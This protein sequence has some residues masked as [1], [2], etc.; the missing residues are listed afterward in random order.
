[1]SAI[2]FL[3][4]LAP[5]ILTQPSN[6][7]PG[8]DTLRINAEAVKA[9]RFDFS[10]NAAEAIDRQQPQQEKTTK[11]WLDYQYDTRLLRTFIDTA[12][13]KKVNGYE[14]LNPYSIWTKLGEAPVHDVLVY[15]RPTKWEMYWQLHPELL[16]D[17]PLWK[18]WKPSVGYMYDLL[19]NSI[20]PGIGFSFSADQLLFETFTRQG[21][22]ISCNRKHAN[23]WKI[24][25]NYIP[26]KKDW[27]G[28][29]PTLLL[30]PDTLQTDSQTHMKSETD[31]LDKPILASRKKKKQTDI[32]NSLVAEMKAKQQQDSIQRAEILGLTPR[33][34][35]VYEVERQIKRMKAN[36]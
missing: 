7:Q 11:K 6:H 28:L 19:N 20:G 8:G 13:V 31:S 1:M 33:R 12:H 2:Y 23:A 10:G 5:L 21:R 14:R 15:G 4:V 17:E 16:T 36:E 32:P 25:A 9:I 18:I 3:T 27:K 30:P 34:Q 35:N 24:Y 22:Y 29:S 26:S